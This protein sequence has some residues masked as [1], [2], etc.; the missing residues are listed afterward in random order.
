M[1]IY[2]ETI[3][4][5][6][7]IPDEE[8]GTE[9]EFEEAVQ[10][11]TNVNKVLLE[12]EWYKYAQQVP[13][14]D[15]PGDERRL[16]EHYLQTYPDIRALS[17]EEVDSISEIIGRFTD[18]IDKLQPAQTVKNVED[19]ISIVEDEKEFLRLCDTFEEIQVIPFTYYT[20]KGTVRMKFDLYPLTDSEAIT[21]I[22][23]NISMFKDFTNEEWDVYNKVQQDEKLSHEEL[24]IT[25]RMDEKNRRATQQNQRQTII[26]Y[27]SLQLKFHG[28]DS[29]IT[30]MREVFKHI[31]F[32]FLAL[33]FNEVQQRNH[34]SDLNVDNVFQ[35]FSE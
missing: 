10:D 5:T 6:I 24:L 17:D 20:S 16:L 27:L 26:E 1:E 19:N 23:S 2:D 22:T 4:R 32:T 7:I 14:Q 30:D 8:Q 12:D 33:L 15:L 34:I 9:Q 25:A 28:K 13:I 18:A 35:E 21:D 31:P 3:G 11:T 29:S